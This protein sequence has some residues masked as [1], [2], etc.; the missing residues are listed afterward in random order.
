MRIPL[1]VNAPG[2]T[3]PGSKTDSLACHVDLA[4]TIAEL[5]G[6]D[7]GDTPTL[8]GESLAPLFDDRSAKIRDYVLFAQEWPWYSGVEHTRYASSGIFDGRHKY[9]R[10]YGIGGGSDAAGNKLTGDSMLFG[11]DA[12]FDDHDHELYD[13]HE[14]PHEMI[15]LAMDRG[16]RSE[17]QSRFA[18]LRAIEHET[19]A[20]GY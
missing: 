11:R 5:G 16:H 8:R 19:Y 1:Y 7:V 18:E 13:L 2:V 17:L 4:R 10:Y 15:N 6:V 9:C 12:G 14:D 20:N 3:T